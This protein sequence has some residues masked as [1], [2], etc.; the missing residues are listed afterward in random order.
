MQDTKL[1]GFVP[2]TDFEQA[3]RFYVDTLGLEFVEEDGFALVLR[4][5]GN[6]MR[7]AKVGDFTP[8]KYTVLGWETPSIEL[9]I[10]ELAA[11]GIIFVRYPWFE[12]DALGIWTAPDGS[13]VAWFNDPDGNVL[14]LSQHA[15]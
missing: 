13:R 2:T 5:G 12:Q 14:S 10:T 3:R 15:S 6:M 7:V 8:A 1:I 9:R 11:A 4:S